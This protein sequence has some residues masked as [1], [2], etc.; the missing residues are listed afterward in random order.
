LL[1]TMQ[2]A[3]HTMTASGIWAAKAST[4]DLVA[5][6]N[7]SSSLRTYLDSLHKYSGDVHPDLQMIHKCYARS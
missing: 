6:S 2:L 3:K 4:Q 7:I 5:W 1:T